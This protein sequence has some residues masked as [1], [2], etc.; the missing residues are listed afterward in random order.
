MNEQNIKAQMLCGQALLQLGKEENTLAMVENGIKRLTR[1]YSL[2]SSQN[3]RAF[4]KDILMY[5][6]RGKKLH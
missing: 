2:C 3:K 4:E 5:L 1:A 6:S